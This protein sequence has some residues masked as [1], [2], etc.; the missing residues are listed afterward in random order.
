MCANS[1]NAGNRGIPLSALLIEGE[2]TSEVWPRLK[3]LLKNPSEAESVVAVLADSLWDEDDNIAWRAAILLIEQGSYDI[4]GLAQAL[5]RVG[6]A[7]EARRDTAR[8]QLLN[9][10]SEPSTGLAIRG[11]LL[12]GIR[13]SEGKIASPA[14]A[15]LLVDMLEIRDQERAARIVT[16]LLRDPEQIEEVIP[17]L[18]KLLSFHFA[19]AVIQAVGAYFASEKIHAGVASR[20]AKLLTE[21]GHRD[22]PNL[23]RR[24]SQADSRTNRIMNLQQCG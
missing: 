18:A 17:R 1:K 6:L 24:S 14:S 10:S 22:V 23:A 5:V 20:C 8:Q 9:A 19:S 7:S 13:S 4:P 21:T 12:D 3:E 15:V 11:A 2:D 16:A